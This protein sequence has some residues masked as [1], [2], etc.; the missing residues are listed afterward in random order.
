MYQL[1]QYLFSN[2]DRASAINI[3]KGFPGG[4]VVKNPPGNAG[5]VADMDLIPGT[6]ICPGVGNGNPLQY[7]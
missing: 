3:C 6:G 1:R 5:D 7:S 2:I 4:S